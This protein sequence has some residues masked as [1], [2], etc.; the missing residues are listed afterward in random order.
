MMLASPRGGVR[1]FEGEKA[2]WKVK[3]TNERQWWKFALR[4]DA[5]YYLFLL[6]SRSCSFDRSFSLNHPQPLL[7]RSSLLSAMSKQ[8]L[9]RARDP[10]TFSFPLPRTLVAWLLLLAIA[11]SAKTR[12]R[13]EE[14]DEVEIILFH[15]FEHFRKSLKCP[16]SLLL[17]FLLSKWLNYVFLSFLFSLNLMFYKIQNQL[18]WKENIL[19]T[20]NNISSIS[21]GCLNNLK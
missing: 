15:R 20:I 8:P 19:D 18:D 17:L 13:T 5:S 6:L 9:P 21:Y 1:T 4:K 7:S 12:E 16:F 10:F 2:R 11:P 3:S 14:R